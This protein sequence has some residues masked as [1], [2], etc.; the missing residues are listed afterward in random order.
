MTTPNTIELLKFAELQ[1]AAEALL[2]QDEATGQ[3]KSDLETALIEGNGHP[4]RFTATEA[5]AFLDP[6]EGWTVVDQCANT[7]SGFSGTLFRSN[8]TSE[9][10][11]SL[12]S[13]E[14]IDDAARDNKSTNTLEIAEHG[15]A[16]GQIAAMEAWYDKLILDGKIT[17]PTQLSVTGYSL[18]GHLATAFNLLRTEAG[19]PL[20]QVVT[21]NG[22]GIGTWDTPTLSG[23]IQQFNTLRT[24]ADTE[25][26]AAHVGITDS[27]LAALYNRVRATVNGGQ[28]AASTDVDQLKAW[29]AYAKK[30]G[31][32]NAIAVQIGKQCDG[33]LAALKNITSILTE[34]ERLKNASAIWW[35]GLRAALLGIDLRGYSRQTMPAQDFSGIRTFQS[36][37]Q[38]VHSKVKS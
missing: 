36:V 14:F 18:G 9:L 17:D 37:M 27:D 25:S 16:Y 19:T 24:I 11:I 21:F 35:T 13:T 10:V 22:A 6:D 7:P 31:I 3:L 26:A 29:S 34:V 15:L 33:I 32:G 30:D 1:M 12:R 23:L 5:Q 28:S 8:K 20:K 4:S 38:R 2:V